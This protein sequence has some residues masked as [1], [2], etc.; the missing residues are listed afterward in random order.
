MRNAARS[1][2]PEAPVCPACHLVCRLTNGREVY[3]HRPDLHD[4]PIW[5]CDGCDGYVGCHPGTTRPLGTPAGAELRRARMLL[6]DQ[7]IDPLWMTAIEAGGY[8]PEDRAAR[9]KIVRAARNR[10]Y[11]FLAERLGLS[12]EETHTAFF[13]LETCRRAW[14]ALQGVTYPEIRAWAHRRRSSS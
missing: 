11:A 12:R 13:D 4:K 9:A 8:Q 10:V 5:R 6:H 1:A 14:R 7:M 3:S 2:L